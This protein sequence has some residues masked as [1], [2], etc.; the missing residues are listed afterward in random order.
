[1]AAGFL[2]GLICDRELAEET[3]EHRIPPVAAGAVLAVALIGDG[4]LDRLRETL[5]AGSSV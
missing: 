5:D 4:S 3:D 2:D 1:M